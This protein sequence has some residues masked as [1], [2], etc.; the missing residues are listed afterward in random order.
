MYYSRESKFSAISF[1]VSMTTSA[2]LILLGAFLI[3]Y[4][5]ALLEIVFF[6]GGIILAIF[7]LILFLQFLVKMGQ[8]K[9]IDLLV[10]VLIMIVGLFVAIFARNLMNIG[11][12]AVG[13]LFLTLG[14]F[15][16]IYYHRYRSTLTLI[17]GILR[18]IIGLFLV[19]GGTTLFFMAVDA[20]TTDTIWITFGYVA[21]TFGVAATAIDQFS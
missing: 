19:I 5:A 8:K 3:K 14:I 10:A 21:I 1:N 18:I 15:D 20:P 11:I 6:T 9:M 17:M 7:G 4:K 16:L 12:M 13:T 2:A